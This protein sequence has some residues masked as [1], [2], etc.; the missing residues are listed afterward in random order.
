MAYHWK[1]P[2]L[3]HSCII[4]YNHLEFILCII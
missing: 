1:N 3:L 4:L 2:D